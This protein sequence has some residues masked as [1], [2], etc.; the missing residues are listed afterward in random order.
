MTY[1]CWANSQ[2]SVA[3]YT[4]GLRINGHDYILA[5]EHE[6]RYTPDLL[7]ADWQTI[8]QKLG[9]HK[10]IGLIKNGTT[11]NVAKQILKTMKPKKNEEMAMDCH[12]LFARG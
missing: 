9:R 11:L 12:D 4:G 3:R 1:E 8:Y 10:T 6:N 5:F 2:F 7:R